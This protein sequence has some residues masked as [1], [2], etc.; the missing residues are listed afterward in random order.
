MNKTKKIVFII[1]GLLLVSIIYE[2]AIKNNSKSYSSYTKIEIPISQYD[3]GIIK[4]LDTITYSF[5]IKNIG[6]EL[7]V[8]DNISTISSNV[9]LQIKDSILPP[10]YE[11]EINVK[12]I[13]Q[14]SNIGFNKIKISVRGNFENKFTEL[15]LTG[16]VSE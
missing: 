12:F 13:P 6:H 5:K 3:F 15:N 10:S 14:N 7:L 11:S 16:I 9:N 4:Y 1:I 8:I 2:I